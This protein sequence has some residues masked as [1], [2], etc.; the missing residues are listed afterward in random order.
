MDSQKAMTQY[1]DVSERPLELLLDD[2]F[3]ASP[4]SFT[5]LR[6]G[7]VKELKAQ[8]RKD[9]AATIGA[10]RK[11]TQVLW[12]LNSVGRKHPELVEAL[13]QHGQKANL[14]QE[15]LLAGGTVALLMAA[16]DQRNTTIGSLLK[17]VVADLGGSTPPIS[18][19]RLALELISTD[20]SLAGF[21]ALGRLTTMPTTAPDPKPADPNPVHLTLVPS[22]PEPGPV[23]EP[24]TVLKPE[25]V[26]E[27]EPQ[28]ETAEQINHKL[29]SEAIHELELREAEL[30]LAQSQ[31][32]KLKSSFDEAQERAASSV[33][34]ITAVELQI[35]GLQRSLLSHNEALEDCRT[36]LTALSPVCI[37]ATERLDQARQAQQLAAEQLLSLAE[38]D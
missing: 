12:V 16:V 14:A 3:A 25:T 20:A 28:Q 1:F 37:D 24:E 35:A 8:K 4:E 5:A 30:E 33:Q 9:D 31:Y 27:P 21:L 17:L 34:A 19:V 13:L 38:R 32:Q 23:L 36:E 10:I 18:S 6:D 2:V 26:L 7:M 22:L 15:A 29:R 11:P